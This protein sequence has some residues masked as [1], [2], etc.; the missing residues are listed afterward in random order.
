VQADAFAGPVGHRGAGELGA[1]VAAQHGRIAPVDG[2]AVEFV[3][4][5]SSG[6][7]AL[8]QAA[9]AFTGVFG[10]NGD[11]LDR[12]AVGGGANWKSTAHTTFGASAVGGFGVVEAPRRLRRRRF[13]EEIRAA[14]RS[15][16]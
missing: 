16:R 10:H 6:D 3:D 15:L 11:D 7:V 14:F 5:V 1:V 8:D 4:Q 13:S 12:S 9:E 2:E